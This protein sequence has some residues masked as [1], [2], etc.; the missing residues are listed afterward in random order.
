MVKLMHWWLH[1]KPNDAP[2]RG[3]LEHVRERRVTVPRKLPDGR[4]Q[5]R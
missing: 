4:I 2:A 1:A 3:L 5:S